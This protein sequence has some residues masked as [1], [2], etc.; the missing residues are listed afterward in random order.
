MKIPGPH[1]ERLNGYSHK[2]KAMPNLGESVM[3]KIFSSRS[4]CCGSLETHLT[5]IHKDA[6]SILGLAQ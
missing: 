1:A 5:S 4:S 3:I 2:T 6:G